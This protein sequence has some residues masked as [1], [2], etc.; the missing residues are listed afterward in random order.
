MFTLSSFYKSK[1][2]QNFRDQVIADRLHDD[3]F[4][5]DE[6]TNKPIVNAYDIILHHCNIFLTEDNVN[7]FNISLNPENIMIVSHKSHNLI[8]NK[9]GYVR[10]EVYLVYGSPLSG[11]T[12]FVKD[13]AGAGDL[14][15]DMDSIWQCISG[16]ERYVKPG[17]L[18][19]IAFGMRD[20]LIDCIKMRK[21]KWN[22]AYLIGGYPF[23][24]ERERLCNTLGAREVFLD[25]SKE[26]CYARLEKI[27]DARDKAEWKKYID[28]WFV[29]ANR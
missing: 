3:G 10:P 8:H 6:Y 11:K 29:R 5:Y 18:N 15:V 21:G 20:Y 19:S 2:W 12:T 17:R 16:Q 28:D 26:E 23:I 4:T 22:N 13:A 25:V 1:L 9:F 27:N 24:G 14:I 7:D